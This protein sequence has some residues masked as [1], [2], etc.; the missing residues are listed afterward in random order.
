MVSSHRVHG[1][2][3][4]GCSTWDSSTCWWCSFNACATRCHKELMGAFG[5]SWSQKSVLVWRCLQRRLKGLLAWSDYFAPSVRVQS[6]RY[7]MSHST[8]RGLMLPLR[9]SSG[10][11]T[12][13]RTWVG[14]SRMVRCVSTPLT[15]DVLLGVDHPLSRW[16]RF[17]GGELFATA[18]WFLRKHEGSNTRSSC[19]FFIGGTGISNMST[20]LIAL[21]SLCLCALATPHL[22][23]P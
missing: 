20:R 12:S 2:G 6:V 14:R 8:K 10:V 23:K 11:L 16:G 1:H 5:H 22:G 3:R 21:T 13:K 19:G 17:M 18:P 15:P 7:P 9:A 4:G